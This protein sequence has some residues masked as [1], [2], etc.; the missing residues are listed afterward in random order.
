M[1]AVVVLAVVTAALAARV[2]LVVHGD[3]DPHTTVRPSMDLPVGH[4]MDF[5]R[6]L[7]VIMVERPLPT[8]VAHAMVII[9]APTMALEALVV[10]GVGAHG[11]VEA[12]SVVVV[13]VV[14]ASTLPSS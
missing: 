14:V 9:T 6:D 3:V 4:L 2:A 7:R 11:V 1:V 10:A 13:V 8:T 12:S 5:P